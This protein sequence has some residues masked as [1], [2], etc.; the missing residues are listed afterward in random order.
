M[1]TADSGPTS[2]AP[3]S[4]SAEAGGSSTTPIG[5]TSGAG[6]GPTSAEGHSTDKDEPV[7]PGQKQNTQSMEKDKPEVG[8]GTIDLYRPRPFPKMNLGQ[9]DTLKF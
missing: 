1:M 8:E 2:S 9:L 7:A 3:T 4:T 6:S 5:G